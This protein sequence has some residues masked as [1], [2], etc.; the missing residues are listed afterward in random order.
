MSYDFTYVAL[1]S[2]EHKINIFAHQQDSV[3]NM[4]YNVRTGGIK[5]QRL[6][7]FCLL[8]LET[9][10]KNPK[11]TLTK[12]LIYGLGIYPVAKTRICGPDSR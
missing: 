2:R 7:L 12:I 9:I 3:E 1:Y 5:I 8:I 6:I 11:S 10:S 4:L